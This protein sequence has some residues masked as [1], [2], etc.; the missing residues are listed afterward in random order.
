MKKIIMASLVAVLMI[1]SL[2]F[3][4]DNS[5]SSN[6]LLTDVNIQE[7]KKTED[8]EIKVIEKKSNIVEVEQR[9][10]DTSNAINI[11]TKKE[12]EEKLVNPLKTN[13]MQS[14]DSQISSYSLS[15]DLVYTDLITE[16][17]QVNAYEYTVTS[18]GKLTVYLETI[19]STSVDYNLHVFKLNESTNE[20]EEQVSSTYG[21][22]VHEQISKIVEVGTYYILVQSVQ[23]L[24]AVNPYAFI[25]KH[26][27]TYSENE[28]NDN[29]WQ[30]NSYTNTLYTR[31]TIDN[32]FDTD[33]SYLNITSSKELIVNMRSLSSNYQ[34]DFFDTNLNYLLT[35]NPNANY[36]I[37][38]PAGQY[39]IRI[40]PL[41]T[42]TL[43]QEYV[44]SVQE[45]VTSTA[46]ATI[47]SITSDGGVQGKVDY[48]Y[49]RY[50]RIKSNITVNGQLK[51]AN[52]TLAKNAPVTVAVV[53]TINNTVHS[54]TGYT[55]G[56]GNF[57][58][59]I[60]NIGPAAGN[61]SFYN[62]SSTHYYDII[63]LLVFSGN[64]EVNSSESI[65]YHFAYSMYN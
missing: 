37:N 51:N 22:G 15:P 25:I 5:T 41:S 55:D 61:Y 29:I 57:S 56:S 23:G 13:R 49:G 10:L 58:I 35:L 1:P 47:T 63:P 45:P 62:I 21:P 44:F 48:G 18:P 6:T 27:A 4:S 2:A 17:G 32:G 65:L 38:F 50:W 59:S 31:D 40:T 60:N 54:N 19:A 42:D 30:A 26:S 16:E 28:P 14:E 20:L 7:V 3:A 39:L 24:D 34:I 9:T 43:N 12:M 46:N 53:R 11:N 33:W 36:S 64:N 8:N 52:G